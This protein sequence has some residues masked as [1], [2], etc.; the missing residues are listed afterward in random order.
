M[1]SNPFVTSGIIPPE[2]FC[3]REKESERIVRLLTNGNN[4]VLISPRRLGKT[5]LI[6]HCFNFPE[7]KDNYTTIF[8]DILQ[9]TSLQEF[10]FLL[11]KA[12]YEAVVPKGKKLVSKFIET[13]KSLSGK[14]TYD[15]LTGSPSFSLQI[16][17]ILRPEFTLEE[18]FKFIE[19]ASS[20]CIVAIDEFQQIT[21]YPERNV[22]A[23]LRTHIQH[24]SNCNFIFAGSKQHLINEMFVSNARPFYHS[25]VLMHL[26]PIP[27]KVYA[28]FA[29]RLFKMYN[30]DILQETVN[31]VYERFGGN[32]YYMQLI[33]NEAFSQT[34]E[35][36]ICERETVEASLNEIIDFNAG[37]YRE[38][39]SALSLR[40]KELLLSIVRNE[41]A[42]GITSSSFIKENSLQSSSSVQAA[43]KKLIEV[44]LITKTDN[45]YSV[46]DRFFAIWLKKTY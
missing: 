38:I 24:T 4:V 42:T 18:I 46:A 29:I 28:E 30:K 20:R 40:Q 14:F 27:Q 44:N 25:S 37:S 3:D 41:P 11:G 19:S 35:E 7:I 9:T 1:Q 22:E 36:E 6:H 45:A 21:E 17:D 8:V 32:T 39:L 23:L 15:P 31:E 10:T 12:V 33:F 2:F 26:E 5:G 43:A 13:L 34:R 16:G